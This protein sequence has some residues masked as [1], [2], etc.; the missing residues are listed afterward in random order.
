MKT[1]LQN[2]GGNATLRTVVAVELPFF[3]YPMASDGTVELR[4]VAELPFEWHSPLTLRPAEKN[5]KTSKTK[6]SRRSTTSASRKSATA[7]PNDLKSLSLE[8]VEGLLESDAFTKQQ[9][10][11]LGHERFGISRPRLLRARKD[12]A[13]SEI[14]SALSEERTMDIIY[15]QSSKIVRTA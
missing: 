2:S 15:D 13:I 12:H 7:L 10:A 6:R 9:I 11:D 3:W 1:S 14:F 8:D 4:K 5:K